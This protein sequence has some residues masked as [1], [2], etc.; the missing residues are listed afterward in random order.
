V[1]AI[2]KLYLVQESNQVE[3]ISSSSD[4]RDHYWI[5]DGVFFC[6]LERQESGSISTDGTVIMFPMDD[7]ND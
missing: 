5:L 3:H 6:T 1:P 7:H 4:H 2:E